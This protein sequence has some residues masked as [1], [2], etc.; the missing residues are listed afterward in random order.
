M[1]T[2]SCVFIV[3][4]EDDDSDVKGVSNLLLTQLIIAVVTLVLTFLF[5]RSAPKTPPR[6]AVNYFST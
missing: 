2:E 5:F 4:E 1:C 3:T 6:Y